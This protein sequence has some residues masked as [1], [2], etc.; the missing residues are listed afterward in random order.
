[1][2][3]LPK[4]LSSAKNLLRIF[5]YGDRERPLRDWL[6]MSAVASV[7]FFV[8]LGW[9]TWIF[10][11]ATSGELVSL[12]VPAKTQV[13]TSA[14]ETAH[15]VFETRAAERAHYLNDYRFVDPSR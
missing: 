15:H 11:Q 7:L 10:E 6:I 3:K 4:S 13:S 8:G 2:I 5:R 9:N 1:M 12:S 14:V